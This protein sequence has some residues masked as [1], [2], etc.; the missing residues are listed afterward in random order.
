MSYSFVAD[1]AVPRNGKYK[2]MEYAVNKYYERAKQN[3]QILPHELKNED[4]EA[5]GGKKAAIQYAFEVRKKRD[6][7]D[8]EKVDIVNI[9]EEVENLLEAVEIMDETEVPEE[10]ESLE[11]ELEMQKNRQILLE[12]LRESGHFSTTKVK[13]DMAKDE[14]KKNRIQKKELKDIEVEAEVSE[15]VME[16]DTKKDEVPNK[17]LA[18]KDE[19]KVVAEAT[20]KKY[21]VPKK[22]PDRKEENKKVVGPES[23]IKMVDR[24]PPQSP[25]DETPFGIQM[26]A[27]QNVGFRGEATD[28]DD[29]FRFNR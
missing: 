17:K 21:E 9:Q 26:T 4:G 19:N 1:R 28:E 23:V 22:K 20:E 13:P 25:K 7:Q 27:N 8:E 5:L 14:K 2:S 16:E 18:K 11:P 12:K 10:V 3:G 6:A 29:P 24:L 15:V